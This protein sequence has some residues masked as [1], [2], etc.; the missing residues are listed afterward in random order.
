MTMEYTV[1]E[2]EN[3][4]VIIN[5][6]VTMTQDR[7]KINIKLSEEN[8]SKLVII[9]TGFLSDITTEKLTE[10]ED[11]PGLPK[12][13]IYTHLVDIMEIFGST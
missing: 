12:W 1:S 10:S 6:Y 11:T 2:K 7:M 13:I 8:S 5:P 9:N 4:G 3:Y